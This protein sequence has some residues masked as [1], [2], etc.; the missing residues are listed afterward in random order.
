MQKIKWE[1]GQVTKV[2]F[3]HRSQ[4]RTLDVKYVDETEKERTLVN[5]P[6]Q[7]FAPLE[8]ENYDTCRK[9]LNKPVQVTKT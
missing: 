6:V 5:Y 1:I 4:I 9:E 7:Y 2:H 8:M 3:N